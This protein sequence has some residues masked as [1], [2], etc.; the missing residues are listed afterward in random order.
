M[1]KLPIDTKIYTH[2]SLHGWG[3][4]YEK[5]E[6]GG[7]WN[8]QEQA[9]HINALEF[10]RSKLGLFRFSK[11]IKT[12]NRLGLITW[13]GFGPIGVMILL[14]TCG[15]GQQKNKYGFQQPTSQDMKMLWQTKTP[16]YLNG[17]QNRNLGRACSNTLSAHLVNQTLIYLH[18]E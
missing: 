10:L 8:K 17:P 7:M 12:L 13:G 2:A 11:T 18:L 15:S 14:L 4:V 6:T 5:S 9:L 16:E 1:K 3:T